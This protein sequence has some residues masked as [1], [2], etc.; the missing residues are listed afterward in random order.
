MI[1]HVYI[2]RLG[3]CGPHTVDGGVSAHTQPPLHALWSDL[4]LTF[5][6]LSSPPR[7]IRSLHTSR[8]TSSL[9]QP[10]RKTRTAMLP[11]SASVWSDSTRRSGIIQSR[12]RSVVRKRRKSWHNDSILLTWLLAH[13]FVLF[14]RSTI[15]PQIASPSRRTIREHVQRRMQSSWRSTAK[16]DCKLGMTDQLQQRGIHMSYY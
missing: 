4:R 3:G 5:V 6:C 12:T 9:L 8:F 13:L 10:T 7:L 11:S 2:Y 16:Q 15:V 1:A 14:R